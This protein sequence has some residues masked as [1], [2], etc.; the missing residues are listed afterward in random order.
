MSEA[1]GFSRR[2]LLALGAIGA[3]AALLPAGARAEEIESHGLSTFGDLAYPADFSHF[4]YVDPAA[5][6]GGTLSQQP[7]TVILNQGFNTFDSLHIY[8]LKGDGAAGVERCFAT[9]MARAFD[10]ADTLY[11][12]AA[13]SVRTSADRL[14]YRFFLR[15]GITFHDGTPITAEDVAWTFMTLKTI[16]HPQIAATLQAMIE[17][18]AEAPDTVLVRLAP[19]RGRSLPLTIA[20]LPIFSKAWWKDRD[21]TASSLTVPLGSGPYRVGRVAPGQFVE[22]ERVA[23][24]WGETLPCM[25]GQN[26]FDRLRFEYFRDREVAFE[27][28]KAK[29]FLFREEFTSRIWATGYDFPAVAS[30]DV[31]RETVEDQTPSGAQGWFFNTRRDKFKDARV[32]QALGLA[33]DFAW[34]NKNIMFSSFDRTASFFQNSDMMATAAPGPD[35]LAILE[36]FRD[37][38]PATVFGPAVEPPVSDGSGSDRGLLRQAAGLLREAGWVLQSGKLQNAAGEPFTIEFLDDDTSLERHT[39][40]LIANLGRLGIEA[41]YRVVDAAQFQSRVEVFDFDMLVRRYSL[42]LTPGDEIRSFWSSKSAAT[43]G[44]RNLAGI[45]DP[46]V[47]A[48]IEAIIAADSR[49]TLNTACRALDRVLRAGHYWIPQWY[50]ASNWFAYWNVF[51]KPPVKPRYAR[52]VTETWWSKT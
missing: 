49:A 35:E 9:L 29:A 48:L 43:P 50:K 2:Q 45:S 21:F 12:Y 31:V 1:G 38:L 46:V 3:A 40:P 37:R 16:G 44:S 34:T 23:G 5:P 15:P 32:R 42:G 18:V 28:F 11:A 52:G 41:S 17:A 6:K 22:F 25:V 4:A 36:P 20:S 8:T 39:A 10:E 26:N 13:R 7:P 27:A 51:A 47:D 24:W 19:E 30:G 33:F 14:T